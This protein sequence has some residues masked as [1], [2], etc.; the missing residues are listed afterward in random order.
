MIL[1]DQPY[2]I[3]CTNTAINHSME[4]F[5]KYYVVG[6]RHFYVVFNRDSFLYSGDYLNMRTPGSDAIFFTPMDNLPQYGWD[7]VL[8][9]AESH[10]ALAKIEWREEIK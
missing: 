4:Q 10:E 3:E 6:H 5:Q 9:D 7:I 8:Y 1:L 2:F